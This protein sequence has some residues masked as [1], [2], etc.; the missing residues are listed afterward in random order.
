MGNIATIVYIMKFAKSKREQSLV[1]VSLCLRE[2]V[3]LVTSLGVMLVYVLGRSEREK[4]A[5]VPSRCAAVGL[6]L[7]PHSQVH[8]R[9]A[10][11]P[12]RLLHDRRRHL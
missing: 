8:E 4:V 9:L 6:I 1:L 7:T 3:E 12:Q 11:A 2:V 5:V 10:H